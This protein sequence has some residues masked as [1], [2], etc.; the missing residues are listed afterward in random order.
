M[1]RAGVGTLPAVVVREGA[2]QHGREN[3]GQQQAGPGSR[4]L[5]CSSV[6]GHAP[7]R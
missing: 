7:G 4:P 5:S 2:E 6:L 1:R 3:Q